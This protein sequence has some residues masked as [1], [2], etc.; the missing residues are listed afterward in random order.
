MSVTL[1]GV[2]DW[3]ET[4]AKPVVKSTYQRPI[5]RVAAA[6]RRWL[7]GPRVIGI[8]GS[9]GKTTTKELVHAALAGRYRCTKSVNSNN[10][11]YDVARSVLGSPPWIQFCVQEV[12]A[13][14]P[15]KLA[16]MMA[17]LRPQ[18]GV[19][20]NVGEDHIYAFGSRE[21]VAAEKRRARHQPAGRWP[22]RAQCR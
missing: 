4:R 19:V 1:S 6:Y 5:I 16:P 8:T 11:L 17:V 22:G 21:A 20:T 2:V 18:V 15:G 9:A 10:Q 14:V 12:G 7:P 3:L 13:S